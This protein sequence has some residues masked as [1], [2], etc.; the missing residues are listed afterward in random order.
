ME[1]IGLFLKEKTMFQ[2]LRKRELILSFKSSLILEVIHAYSKNAKYVMFV[3][4]SLLQIFFIR[5]LLTYVIN[6]MNLRLCT[7]LRKHAYSN[8]LKILPPKK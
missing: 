1:R 8:I 5:T 3:E 7:P 4:V 6:V 2:E